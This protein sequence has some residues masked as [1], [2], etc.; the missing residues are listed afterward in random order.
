MWDSDNDFIMQVSENTR[1][2][3]SRKNLNSASM[4]CNNE[5]DKSAGLQRQGSSSCFSEGDS[6]PSL[7]LNGGTSSSLSPKDPEAPNLYRK[8]RSTSCPGTDPQTLYARVSQS[9]LKGI[10]STIS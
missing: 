10:S 1:N 3:K 8:L 2:A 9:P 5:E 7:E 4:S 6:N